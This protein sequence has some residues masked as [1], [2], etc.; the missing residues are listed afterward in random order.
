MAIK[1]GYSE[2]P[3]PS[4]QKR[5]AASSTA[6]EKDLKPGGGGGAAGVMKKQI[7]IIWQGGSQGALLLSMAGRQ[8]GSFQPSLLLAEV[9]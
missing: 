9:T 2:F 4:L 8:D 6:G 5:C 3:K 1:E 7:H